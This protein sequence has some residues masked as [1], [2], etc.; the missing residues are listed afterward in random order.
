MRALL[1]IYFGL[2]LVTIWAQ[3]TPLPTPPQGL[4][5]LLNYN[6]EETTFHLAPEDTSPSTISPLDLEKMRPY[7]IVKQIE[8]RITQQRAEPGE[9]QCQC[10]GT[11]EA[12]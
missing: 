12:P 11:D 3:P 2:S 5:Y 10:A 6:L 4:K 9:E 7:T 8:K 1:S